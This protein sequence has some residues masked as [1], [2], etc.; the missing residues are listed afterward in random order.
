MKIGDWYHAVR[1]YVELQTRRNDVRD[2][3][4]VTWMMAADRSDNS[5]IMATD[6]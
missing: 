6:E 2:D 1:D 5:P 3:E 4:K